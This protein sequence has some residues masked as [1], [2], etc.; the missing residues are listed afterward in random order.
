MRWNMFEEVKIRADYIKTGKLTAERI[1]VS[2]RKTLILAFVGF[3]REQTLVHFRQF[4]RD[5]AE[6]IYSQDLNNGR[7]HL[8]DGT[9]II[10]VVNEEQVRMYG[11]RFDQIILADDRRMM[12]WKE[13]RH[14]LRLLNMVADMRSEVPK[15]FRFQVYDV[16]APEV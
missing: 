9:I 3:N 14:L 4:A 11:L 1:A 13:R 10:R 7:I 8:Y 12:I 15:E 2:D 6:Q 16:D 5:N